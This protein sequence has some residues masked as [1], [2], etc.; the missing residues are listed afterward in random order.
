MPTKR[1]LKT[2][3]SGL[4]EREPVNFYYQYD[5]PETDHPKIKVLEPKKSVIKGTY[6]FT[7]KKDVGKATFFT[8]LIKTETEGQIT[9]KGCTS[10][11]NAL[12]TLARGTYVELKYLG[13]GKAKPGQSKPYL[14]DMQAEDTGSNGAATDEDADTDTTEDADEIF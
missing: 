14:W 6:E 9:I 4:T 8:H 11:N 13:R 10:L 12:T 1:K 7:F 3:S 5:E 2:L